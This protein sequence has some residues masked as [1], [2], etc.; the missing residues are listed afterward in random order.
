MHWLPLST[1]GQSCFLCEL[2]KPHNK[3]G[4]HLCKIPA[5]NPMEYIILAYISGAVVHDMDTEYITLSMRLHTAVWWCDLIWCL[6]NDHCI[7]VASRALI[8]QQLYDILQPALLLDNPPTFS[9]RSSHIK[10]LAPPGTVSQTIHIRNVSDPLA[11]ASM[12]LAP[13]T[14]GGGGG[15]PLHNDAGDTLIAKHSVH[16]VSQ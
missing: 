2:K 14:C 16:C 15:M 4:L 3:R 11:A 9:T 12:H 1:V 10:Y 13:A 8:H 6:H 5:G 7:C